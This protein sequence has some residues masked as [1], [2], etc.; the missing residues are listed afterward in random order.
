MKSI[1]SVSL[2]R[3]RQNKSLLSAES[4]SPPQAGLELVVEALGI[5]LHEAGFELGLADLD[6]VIADQVL[7]ELAV[8][9]EHHGRGLVAALADDLNGLI[10]GNHE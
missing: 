3:V 9:R 2:S 8:D 7:A 5:D 4:L 1:S 10:I 6:L